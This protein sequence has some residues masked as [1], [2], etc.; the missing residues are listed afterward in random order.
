MKAKYILG[1]IVTLFL[2]TG[3][4]PTPNNEPEGV[5]NETEEAENDGGD[6]LGSWTRTAVYLGGELLNTTPAN[7]TFNADG[8][9]GSSGSGCATSGTHEEIDEGTITMV[10][11]QNSCPG[12]IALPLTVTYTYTIGE[13]EDELEQMTTITG[14]QMETYVR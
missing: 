4:G 5:V 9:Y 14:P 3:C 8:T 7:L 1:L 6:Y 2:L 13:T 11:M 12:N 10:M